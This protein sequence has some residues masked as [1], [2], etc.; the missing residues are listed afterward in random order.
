MCSLLY[1]TNDAGTDPQFFVDGL[2]VCKATFEAYKQA[3]R[4]DTFHTYRSGN[5]WHHRCE[6]RE[7]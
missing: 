3:K 2:R 4:A 5:R 6:I 7:H 1:S